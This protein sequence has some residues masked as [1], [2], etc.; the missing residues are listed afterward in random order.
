MKR[1]RTK[2]VMTVVLAGAIVLGGAGA[3]LA[4]FTSTGSGTGSATVGSST[5]LTVASVAPTG[6]P[7]YPDAAIG[8]ANVET[9]AYTVTNPSAG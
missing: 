1:F 7:L 3:A 9:V 4:Y 5:A 8:G 6:G 2:K